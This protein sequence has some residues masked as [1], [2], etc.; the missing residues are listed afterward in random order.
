MGEGAW[1]GSRQCVRHLQL[2]AGHSDVSGSEASGRALARR[3]TACRGRYRPVLL[4]RLAGT[5]AARHR[6][7][8]DGG[9]E[10]QRQKGKEQSD[11]SRGCDGCAPPFRYVTCDFA[12]HT[13]QLASP[14]TKTPCGAS[15]ARVRSASETL[16]IVVG[17]EITFRTGGRAGAT[18]DTPYV[19]HSCQQAMQTSTEAGH[20]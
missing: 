16:F 11:Q 6:A 7:G 1:C 18:P 5:F 3:P 10:R 2:R 15:P 14:A 12:T 19:S 4:H 13:H 8:E 17:G 9:A 20:P